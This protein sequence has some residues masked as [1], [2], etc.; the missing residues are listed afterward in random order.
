MKQ[1]LF[2]R[3]SLVALGI[4]ACGCVA[5]LRPIPRTFRSVENPSLVIDDRG[6]RLEVFP[7][8]RAKLEISRSGRTVYHV[9]P[10][11]ASAPISP[12]ELGV[13]FNH[14]MQVE[15]YINGEVAF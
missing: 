15:G 7:T 5:Q 6:S 3:F 10:R 9:L 14:A 11:D 13:V 4:T 1:T 2:R 12:K 8:K